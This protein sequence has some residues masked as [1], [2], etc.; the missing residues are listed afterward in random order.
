MFMYMYVC[1]YVHICYR[2]EFNLPMQD[3][4]ITSSHRYE[5]LLQIPLNMIALTDRV[6]LICHIC[7]CY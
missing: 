2:A 3:G 6:V 7:G 5:K 1:M 4:K